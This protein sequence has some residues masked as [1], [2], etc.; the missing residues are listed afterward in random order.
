[1]FK[2]LILGITLISNYCL[3]KR[4]KIFYFVPSLSPASFN[5][6]IDAK[7]VNKFSRSFL[8]GN[9]RYIGACYGRGGRRTTSGWLWRRPGLRAESLEFAQF[10]E[11]DTDCLF[12]VSARRPHA[13]FNYISTRPQS[14]SLS[15]FILVVLIIITESN[16]IL[17]APQQ[18]A[19]INK[20]IYTTLK[21]PSNGLRGYINI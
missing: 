2:T 15:L 13:G 9:K 6:I 5:N 10:F 8:T 19:L 11:T 3:R 12:R 7:G 21:V 20:I 16:L 18:G 1:V 14:L 17:H 4:Y